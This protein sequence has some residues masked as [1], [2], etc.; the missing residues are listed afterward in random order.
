M[1]RQYS[2]LVPLAADLQCKPKNMKDIKANNNEELLSVLRNI[3]IRVPPRNEGRTTEHCETWS[4][5]RLLATLVKHSKIGFP[6]QLTKRERPD[7]LLKS[8]GRYIGIEVTEAVN[9]EYAKA[10][11]L[12][13]ADAEGAIIDPSLFKWGTPQRN[14]HDLRSIVSRKKLTGPGW[15][16]NSVESEYADAILHVITVKTEKLQAQD[17]EKFTD[18]WLAVYCNITLP[19]LE[20]ELANLY[21]VERAVNYWSESGFSKVFVEEG[22]AIISYSSDRAEVMELEN[23]WRTG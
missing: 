15:E 3:D 8:E 21:F 1:T 12:P 17:F 13:E 2:R 18:N 7:F 10:A 23:L 5:C 20:L 22:D 11:T 16:G 4:I 9:P 6:M 14:L 19:A